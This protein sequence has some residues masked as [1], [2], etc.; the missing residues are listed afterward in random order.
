MSN[1]NYLRVIDPLIHCII[2]L[3]IG[4]DLKSN[5]NSNVHHAI[6]YNNS[7]E[8]RLQISSTGL[9]VISFI[10]ISKHKE[11]TEQDSNHD[12]QRVTSITFD[13]AYNRIIFEA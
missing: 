3:C 12:V 1:Q 2:N 7:I 11:N 13:H 10:R 8:A 5:K 4:D 6:W 9:Y